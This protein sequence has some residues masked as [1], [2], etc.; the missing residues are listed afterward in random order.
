MT[1]LSPGVHFA[2]AES[3][4]ED[5]WGGWEAEDE[6]ELGEWKWAMVVVKEGEHKKKTGIVTV[7]LPNGCLFFMLIQPRKYFPAVSQW[8]SAEAIHGHCPRHKHPL[9]K[10]KE[11]DD[12]F[13]DEKPKEEDKKQKKKKGPRLECEM[14]K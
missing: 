11:D 1:V 5:W 3:E 9:E 4:D 12:P 10:M 6:G 8:S 7:S 14:C 13:E 2:D